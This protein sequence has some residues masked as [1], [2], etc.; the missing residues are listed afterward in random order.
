MCGIAGYVSLE[1]RCDRR[2]LLQQMT[3]ALRHRGPDDEGYFA[4]PGVGLAIRRLSI[5]DVAGSHQ[6]IS[7][8]DETVHVVFNGAIYNYLELRASLE[9]RG[10]WLKTQG[11]TE[12]LVHLYEEHGFDML[13]FLRG[14]FAF[15]LWD[16]R[17]KT[18]FLARD[19]LGKKPLNYLPIGNELYFCS[20]LAPLLDQNIASWE[21]NPNA[22]AAY[23]LLGFVPG[24]QTMVRQIKRLPPAC[25]LVWRGG[26]I[27][28]KRYW[29]FVGAPKIQCNYHEA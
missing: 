2:P 21:I 10:H 26:E 16:S 23:L 3:Q 25:Y 17:K 20:E 22:L 8:E 28:V 9:K 12:I 7:N 29:S 5:I 24:L 11:D 27:E 18:L 19:R 4:E 14:M 13:H 1:E 15:A 6:P